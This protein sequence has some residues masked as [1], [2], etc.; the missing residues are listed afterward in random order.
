MEENRSYVKGL[1]P[2]ALAAFLISVGGGFSA[3]LGPAFVQDMGI[4]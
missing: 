3:V 1:I 2:Y 4:A